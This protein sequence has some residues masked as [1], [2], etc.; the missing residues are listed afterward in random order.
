M[1]LFFW[2]SLRRLDL[3]KLV[4]VLEEKDISKFKDHQTKTVEISWLFYYIQRKQTMLL[5]RLTAGTLHDASL[6]LFIMLRAFPLYSFL[7]LL[8][9]S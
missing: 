9:E 7:L 2:K 3:P 1:T 5:E 6:P 4:N 8:P